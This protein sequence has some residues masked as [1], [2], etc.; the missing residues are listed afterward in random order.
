MNTKTKRR[1]FVV[2]GIIVIFLIL[3]LALAGGN[4]SARALSLEDAING[5]YVDQ[6]IQVSG[7]VVSNSFETNNNILTFAIYDPSGDPTKQMEVS[8]DGAVSS[9]FGNDVTAIC[10][11]KIGSDGVLYVSELVTKCP[12]KY[13]NATNALEVDALLEYGES[14]YD[15]PVKVVG[16][17]EAGTLKAAGQGERF[18]LADTQG[19]G[20]ISVE[21]EGALPEEVTEGST[22]VLTGSLVNG[23]QFVATDVA[24]EG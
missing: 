24:L 16:V 1:L 18:S 21:F 5:D 12:S 23:S 2:S 4:T 6:K 3:A 15:K 9:S 22:L 14:V 20:V 17:V 8:Y 10:T 7:N 19:N 11:G 13:E